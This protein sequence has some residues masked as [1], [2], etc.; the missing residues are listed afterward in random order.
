VLAANGVR[1]GA[2]GTGSWMRHGLALRG[3]AATAG[4][5]HTV[6]EGPPGPDRV[7]VTRLGSATR[8]WMTNEAALIEAPCASGFTVIA[9][10][11]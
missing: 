8:R 4:Q 7:Y 11:A 10:P 9:P 6:P 5:R 1:L 2:T 3:A